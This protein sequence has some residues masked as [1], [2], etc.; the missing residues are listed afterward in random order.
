MVPRPKAGDGPQATFLTAQRITGL[1]EREVVA[2]DDA[3]LLQGDKVL[4]ADRMTYW[5]VDDEVEAVG[6]VRLQQ[7]D[8][9]ISGPKMRLRLE[10]EG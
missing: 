9:L 7:G 4:T 1:V 6:S 3:E 8:D 2:E 10:D 5:P